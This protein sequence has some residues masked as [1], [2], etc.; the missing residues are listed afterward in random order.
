MTGLILFSLKR[1]KLLSCTSSSILSKNCKLQPAI[2]A[3]NSQDYCYLYI[4][5]LSKGLRSTNLKRIA[6]AAQGPTTLKDG[7]VASGAP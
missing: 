1:C 2:S 4:C 3:F 5:Y 6:L 7:A